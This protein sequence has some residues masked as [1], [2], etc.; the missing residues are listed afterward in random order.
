MLCQA[1]LWCGH[2]Q[3]AG[4]GSQRAAGNFFTIPQNSKFNDALT[5]NPE[6]FVSVFGWRDGGVVAAAILWPQVGALYTKWLNAVAGRPIN[7]AIELR[8]TVTSQ[9]K[10]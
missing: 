5:L 9:T 3:F 1:P 10:N 4:V 6:K 8:P 7:E 2:K